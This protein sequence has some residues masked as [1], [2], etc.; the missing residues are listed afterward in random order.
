MFPIEK[1]AVLTTVALGMLGRDVPQELS[2]V[3]FLENP[4]VQG[5]LNN[6]WEKIW[7]KFLVFG[8]ASAGVMGLYILGKIIKFLLDIGIHAYALYEIYGFSFHLLG[9][10]WDSVTQLSLHWGNSK[11]QDR[12]KRSFPWKLRSSG[13]K[14]PPKPTDPE[15]K[16]STADAEKSSYEL[17]EE[18]EQERHQQKQSTVHTFSTIPRARSRR[19]SLAN[20]SNYLPMGRSSSC[21]PTQLY[22]GLDIFCYR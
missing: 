19:S 8:T 14:P 20:S 22:P 16:P 4:N 10:V 3:P 9:A 1:M 21:E 2:I 13:P 7:G 18:I 12:K 11:D 17:S 5:M 6:T 15:F